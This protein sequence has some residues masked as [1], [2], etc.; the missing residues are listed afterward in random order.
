MELRCFQVPERKEEKKMR[1]KVLLGYLL[2]ISESLK[3]KFNFTASLAREL[4][5]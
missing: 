5:K 3:L 1:Q 2:G 4:R